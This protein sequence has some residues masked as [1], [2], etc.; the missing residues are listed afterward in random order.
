MLTMCEESAVFRFQV[1]AGINVTGI[2]I[3]GQT[4]YWPPD[5]SLES[6]ANTLQ[7]LQRAKETYRYAQLLDRDPASYDP[8]QSC[9]IRTWIPAG[10]LY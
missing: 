8:Y 1:I 5:R 9:S 2:A 7:R 10:I 4:R 6:W 3:H